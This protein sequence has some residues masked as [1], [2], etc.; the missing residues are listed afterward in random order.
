MVESIEARN[1]DTK[2]DNI[3]LHTLSYIQTDHCSKLNIQIKSLT[4]L[5]D[6]MFERKQ[7]KCRFHFL[8]TKKN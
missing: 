3:G 4:T 1:I 2:L 6:P 8:V 5:K 7:I